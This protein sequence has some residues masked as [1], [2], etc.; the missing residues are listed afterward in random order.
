MSKPCTPLSYFCFHLN[1]LSL[2]VSSTLIK[3]EL[4]KN[5]IKKRDINSDQNKISH[6]GKSKSPRKKVSLY[7]TKFDK[8]K[9]KLGMIIYSKT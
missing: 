7:K 2:Q 8:S 3:I 5:T 9:G 6:A 1:E 4:S